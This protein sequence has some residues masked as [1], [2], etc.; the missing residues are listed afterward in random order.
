VDPGGDR[1]AQ[2]AFRLPAAILAKLDEHVARLR[3]LV[4]GVRLTRADAVR[5]LLERGIEAVEAEEREK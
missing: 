2:V 5:A 3:R 4:P 1:A